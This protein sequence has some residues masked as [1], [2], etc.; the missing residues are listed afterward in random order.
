MG[1]DVIDSLDFK[2]IAAY[3]LF[4]EMYEYI[5]ICRDGLIINLSKSV[6][7]INCAIENK[8][9]I[10]FI[11]NYSR[12]VHSIRDQKYTDSR[13]LL[14][15]W[16]MNMITLGCIVFRG[17]YVQKIIERIPVDDKTYSLWQMIAPFIYSAN[18]KINATSI[19]GDI[20]TYNTQKKLQ[21]F[22]IVLEKLFGNGENGILM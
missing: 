13:K 15:D 3:S 4:S 2:L 7:K 10:I 21:H 5:W 9:D 6:D 20:F 16:G 19:I 8:F 22:G 12:D 14:H 1:K 17:D 11:D 18:I